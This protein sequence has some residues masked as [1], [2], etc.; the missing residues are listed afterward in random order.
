MGMDCTDVLCNYHDIVSLGS[1]E[2]DI[3]DVYSVEKLVEEVMPDI[4]LNCAAFSNVDDCE[5]N[6]DLANQVNA[7][8]P[9]NLACIAKK[10]ELRLIHISTDYVFDGKRKVP[11]A[12]TEKDEPCPAT[13]YGR[14][15]LAG[16]K[17]VQ[18]GTDNHVIIRTA[19]LFGLNG[20]N[21]LKAILR[22]AIES[23]KTQIR[24]VN[25][26]FGSPTWSYTLARQ[27]E[28][29]IDIKSNGIYHA[30]SEGYCTWY[31][32]ANTFLKEMDLPCSLVPC[33]S[34]E[35]PTPASRPANS[36]Q[37][38]QRLNNAGINIMENWEID[39]KRFVSKFKPHLIQE[40]SQRG[41]K[42]KTAR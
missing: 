9:K 27:I 25:D 34:E 12:Y 19:W 32:F 13:Y 8:G 10:Y 15:K 35:Y 18:L 14:S 23:P 33:S 38:N 16:E 26:Q 42:Y 3:T 31:E 24:V 17:A 5:T 36:I 28:K 37:K 11:Q 29:L 21:F 30:S 6:R 39:V 1:K 4:I 40:V 22:K 41:L 20:H 2:L 7:E